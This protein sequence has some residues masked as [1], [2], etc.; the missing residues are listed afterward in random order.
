MAFHRR[1]VIERTFLEFVD[2]RFKYENNEVR[3]LIAYV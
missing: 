3:V 1:D 2:E